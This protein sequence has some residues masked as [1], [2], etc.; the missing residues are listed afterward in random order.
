[1]YVQ[2]KKICHSCSMSIN[3]MALKQNKI[4]CNFLP[5]VIYVLKIPVGFMSG[6]A[7]CENTVKI[8]DK[9]VR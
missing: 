9:E 5:V 6:R 8:F 3:N 1:M 2:C 4:Y 7:I